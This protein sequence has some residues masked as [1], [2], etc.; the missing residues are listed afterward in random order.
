MTVT[1]ESDLL[2]IPEQ[3]FVDAELKNEIDQFL[4]FE[5]SLLD[6]RRYMD[7]YRLFATDLQYLM[8]NRSNR[9]MHEADKEN[10]TA[11][12][13]NLFD[14]TYASLGWRVRQVASRKHWAEDPP[15]RARHLVT[16]IKVEPTDVP[17]EYD[18]HANFLIYRNRLESEVDF[19]V[20][21]RRDLLR[22]IEPRAWQIARRTITLDQNVVLSKNFSIFF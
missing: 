8:P 2:K 7:W 6:E 15:S 16:N 20:G 17:D 9:L 5:A 10:T 21:E 12:Q 14:E 1:A 22:R 3:F 13:F 11:T 19:W 18:V 4:F